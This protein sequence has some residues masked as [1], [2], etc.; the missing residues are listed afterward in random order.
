[1]KVSIVY[2]SATGNTEKVARWIQEGAQQAADTEVRLF[3]L[4]EN[5]APDR[6]FIEASSAVVF[7]TPTYVASMCW[8]LKK[9]FDV[10]MEYDLADKIGAA[11]AT[12][13][14]PHGGG[15]EQAV[16]T[17][18]TH[19]LVKGMFVYSSGAGCGRP[20]IHIGPTVVRDQMEERKEIC[21][22]FGKRIAEKAH[23][24]FD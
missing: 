8:Q 9:F 4:A 16:M 10:H 5:D 15:A 21:Q 7:G 1:M 20:Y 6:D 2:F 22:V 18:H 14:S 11:F 19:M 3:N 24:L 17:I 13:N 12:E 23:M